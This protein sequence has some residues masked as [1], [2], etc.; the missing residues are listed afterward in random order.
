[1]ELVK[2]NLDGPAPSGE[3]ARIL[4]EGVKDFAIFRLDPSGHVCSWN[5]GARQLLQ[6]ESKEIVGKSFSTFQPP[7]PLQGNTAELEVEQARRDGRSEVEGWRTR[8]DGSQFWASVVILALSENGE[9]CGF[10]SIMRD[11]SDRRTGDET[12][13]KSETRL[14]LL[15]ESIQDYAV[16]MLEPD[17]RVATWNLGAEKIKGYTASEIIGQSFT[18]FY[19]DEDVRNGK[20]EIELAEAAAKGRF[21][22]E[23][24]RVRKDGTRFWANVVIGPVRDEQGVLIGFS[25]VT[26]DLTERKRSEDERTALLAA[27]KANRAKDDFLAILGHELRNP[28]APIVTALQLMK[29]RGADATKEQVIIERQV[30]LMVRL[31]DE[32]L[33]VSRIANGKIDLKKQ[34]V[35][36][37]EVLVRAIEIVSP[38]FEQRGQS[39]VLEVPHGPFIVE[40]D[41]M[42]LVQIFANLLNNA[43]KYTDAGGR[44]V[45]RV[46]GLKG[47]VTIDVQDDGVGITPELMPRIFDLFVQAEQG[48][49]RAAGGLGIGLALVKSLVALHS[50]QID[51]KSAGPGRGSTFRVTLPLLAGSAPHARPDSMPRLRAVH[52]RRVV[53]VDD[54]ADAVELMSDLLQSQG[55][56]VRTALDGLS[57]LKIIQEFKPDVAVLD[58]GLPV[59]DGY[60]L[61]AR[62]RREMATEAPDLIALTGYG[63]ESDRKRTAKA[64]FS[65]HFVKPV[66]PRALSEAIASVD[67]RRVA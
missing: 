58:L 6:Y 51:A 1:M 55:N 22:D 4:V 52:G 37:G 65:H 34:P 42:R 3:F 15:I 27:E 53:I 17:G 36:V 33:D 28:L 16:F 66:D 12:L 44:I 47:A 2:R 40:G 43:A 18:K 63:Q 50:G 13:W 11:L 39:L 10:A 30:K 14:R 41:S 45:L 5:D 62:L 61:A 19:P 24:W 56:E 64:G 35:D 46:E 26:R 29:L 54:N 23:G 31:V 9:P 67:P 25:K 21:E 38:L 7:E 60:E 49:E 20:C 8:K 48:A 32:L 59:M 57:A